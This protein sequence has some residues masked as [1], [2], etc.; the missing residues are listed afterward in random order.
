MPSRDPDK[1][2]TYAD[3]LTWPENER[4]EIH[5]G[6]PCMLTAPSW[7]HQEILGSLF[8]Q[9]YNYLEGKPCRVF[10]APFD[11]RL[12]EPGQTDEETTF[13]VQPDITVVCDVTKLNRT[14]YCGVPTLIIEI[15]SPATAKID[16]IIK[17]NRFEKMGVPEYWI[18]EPEEKIVSVYTLLENG[19]YGRPEVYP[20]DGNIRVHAFPDLV[21]ELNS[22]FLNKQ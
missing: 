17:F 8:N 5:E 10:C 20:E 9:L 18:V 14:G 11:L 1:R 6:V 12:P 13:V 21:V 7:Q 16:K 22:V 15:T 4:W 19:R 3:C 2:Y